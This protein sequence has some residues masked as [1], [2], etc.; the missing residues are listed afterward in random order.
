MLRSMQAA[1]GR[2]IVRMLLSRRV[3]RG[4]TVLCCTA[5]LSLSA[6]SASAGASSPQPPVTTAPSATSPQPPQPSAPSAPGHFAPAPSGDVTPL[7]Q[8]GPITAGSCT[9]EQ[10]I[11]DPHISSTAPRAA[12]VHGW[13]LRDSGTCPSKA[14]VTVYLQAY[15]CGP[16]YGC[17]WRTVASG[18]AD[19][20]AGGGS[21]NR[22]TARLTC[23]N[24]STVGWRGF[25]DVNLD[26]VSDPSGYT[27]SAI[28]N[29]ACSL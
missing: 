5:L 1:R 4:L 14:T 13:W 26:G 3:R 27:Y 20:Y 19:V 11:D 2:L 9:Y 15:W 21:G 28:K 7:A 23:S 8:S 22:A 25:V 17:Y 29:L 16:F 6:L 10:A 18:Q 24:S 12:S